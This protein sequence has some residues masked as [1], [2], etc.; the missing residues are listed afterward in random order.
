MHT[1]KPDPIEETAVNES[2]VDSSTA[3][4]DN[5][6]SS[7][8]PVLKPLNLDQKGSSIMKKPTKALLA[9]IVLL[10]ILAGVATGFG[11]EKLASNTDGTGASNRLRSGQ[12]I[13][14]VAGE[15][16]SAG[17]IFGSADESTFKD[18][19]QG[20]LQKGGFDGE[21]SHQLVRPG[22]ESQTVYLTSSITDLDKF[23]GMEI[24]IWGETFKGQKVGWLMDVGRV[25]VINP[26]AELPE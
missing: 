25:E 20:V 8:E 21:G 24:K 7:Q 10:P 2:L 4:S 14:Q 5:V 15:T 1:V 11:L 13:Q 16:V 22:G 26:E 17:D 3:V 23:E 9:I 6:D 19:A 18:Q 12:E